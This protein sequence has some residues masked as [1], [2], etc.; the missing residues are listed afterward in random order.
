MGGNRKCR[1]RAVCVY[2]EKRLNSIEYVY[3]E[4]K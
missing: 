2:L 1:D 4:E 3:W